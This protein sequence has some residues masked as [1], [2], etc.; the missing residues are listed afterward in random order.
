[1]EERRTVQTAHEGLTCPRSTIRK[2]AYRI[3][4]MVKYSHE[5]E[6]YVYEYRRIKVFKVF[7]EKNGCACKNID[8]DGIDFKEI[9]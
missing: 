8:D 4:K 1:M 3:T 6:M 9:L 2:E 5:R 7:F